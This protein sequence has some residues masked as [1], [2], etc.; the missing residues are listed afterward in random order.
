MVL[1]VAL[2]AEESAGVQALRLL[3]MRRHEVVAVL[4]G[5][6]AGGPGASV[7]GV[8]RE[9]GLPVQPAKRMSEAAFAEEFSGL[10]LLLN[11]HSL[12]I[13]DPAVIAAPRLGA[14]NLHPGP[15]PEYAG[16]DVVSWAIYEGEQRHGVTLHRMTPEVDAGPIA[17][18]AHFPVSDTDTGLKVMT[19]CVHH[20][21][22]LVE[23]L[24]TCA[25]R[26][27]PIPATPQDLARRRWFG[28]GPPDGGRL[29]WEQP[30]KRVVNLVRAADYRPFRSPWGTPTCRLGRDQIGVVAASC[31]AAASPGAPPGTVGLRDGGSV[32]VAAADA[33]V[34]V[35][36]I[37]VD[38]R[39]RDAATALA[40]GERLSVGDD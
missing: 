20:G 9:L 23:S 27:E 30:A 33:W 39:E 21:R 37:R 6:A 5:S 14:F 10:D 28:A 26:G 3:A 22:T 2:A 19:R 17:F 25:E 31:E 38:G 18:A 1:R 16:L 29:R 40:P 8:A 13:A 32:L 15:L 7:A 4:A 12:H 34:R 35:E 36:R 24:L 11:V